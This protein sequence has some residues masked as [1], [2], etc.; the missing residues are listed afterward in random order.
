VAEAVRAAGLDERTH[1]HTLRHSAATHLA[2]RG[3]D[4][5]VVGAL[6]GHSTMRSTEVY[7][8]TSVRRLQA[9]HEQALS[10]R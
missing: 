3:C 1:A 7:I 10:L 4:L 5:R 6:L 2:D 9:V 8:H